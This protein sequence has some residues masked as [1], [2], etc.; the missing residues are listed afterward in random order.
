MVACKVGVIFEVTLFCVNMEYDAVTYRDAILIIEETAIADA[1]LEI[2]CGADFEVG[3]RE[4][5]AAVD[6]IRAI[7]IIIRRTTGAQVCGGGGRSR[8]QC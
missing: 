4:V 6:I 8:R 1:R 2:R 5:L 7:P 3:A